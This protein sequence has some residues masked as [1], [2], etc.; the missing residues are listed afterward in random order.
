M[1]HGFC[2]HSDNMEFYKITPE[3][4]KKVLDIIG[5]G[6]TKC[7]KTRDDDGRYGEISQKG[8]EFGFKSSMYGFYAFGSYIVNDPYYFEA[9]WRHMSSEEFDD[10]YII[11]DKTSI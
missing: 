2:K 9:G 1:N 5:F 3:N 6:E 4:A 11:V 10:A 8:I 7:L